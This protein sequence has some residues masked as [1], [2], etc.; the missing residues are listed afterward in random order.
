M[1]EIYHAEVCLGGSEVNVRYSSAKL[2][3]FAKSC[4]VTE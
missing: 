4:K 2:M 1:S 3:Q